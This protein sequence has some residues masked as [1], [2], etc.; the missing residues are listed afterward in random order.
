[1]TGKRASPRS[2]RK[3]ERA[4]ALGHMVSWDDRRE[5]SVGKTREIGSEVLTWSLDLR[6]H[7][8]SGGDE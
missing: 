2:I 5:G 8:K 7:E 1:M 4:I 6:S 3:K